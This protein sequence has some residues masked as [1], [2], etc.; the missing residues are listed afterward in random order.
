[1]EQ[2]SQQTGKPL[3]NATSH[4]KLAHL[5]RFFHWLAGTPGYKSRLQYAD[6]DYFNMSAKDTRVATARRESR[7]PTL[8]Q[9]RHVINTMPDKTEI[10]RRDRALLA[11]T[12]LTGARDSAIASMRLKHVDLERQCVYQDAGDVRT[13]FSKTFHTDFFPVGD[14]VRAIVEEWVTWLRVEKLWGCR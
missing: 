7:A 10:E 4:A 14:P 5:K 6:A 8:E 1:M 13:K 3:S 2:C 11:F 12:P 9:V